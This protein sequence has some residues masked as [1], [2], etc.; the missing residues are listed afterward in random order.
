MEVKDYTKQQEL[1]SLLS[2]RKEI[3]ELT[4]NYDEYY[5]AAKKF[6]LDGW[7]GKLGEETEKHIGNLVD[8]YGDLK[9]TIK[10]VSK[11]LKLSKELFSV[12]KEEKKNMKE[13][14]KN[15]D[16]NI[17][18]IMKEIL[19]DDG[20]TEGFINFPVFGTVKCALKKELTITSEQLLKESLVKNEKWEMIKTESLAKLKKMEDL[21]KIEGIEEQEIPK[22][23]IS[24]TK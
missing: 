23:T 22:I 7:D 9:T 17:G 2:A 10:E 12:T 5:E 4:D 11:T 21:D 15:I 13:S 16:D 1:L 8:I 24:S 3:N 6:V 19:H 14:K 20:L 18:K